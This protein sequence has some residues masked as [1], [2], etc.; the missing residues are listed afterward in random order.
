MTISVQITL[1]NENPAVVNSLQFLPALQVAF[2]NWS[3]ALAGDARIQVTL[4]IEPNSFFDG[5]GALASCVPVFVPIG[6]AVD[7][8][9]LFETDC[10]YQSI[11]GA[12]DPN[13]SATDMIININGDYTFWLDPASAP[14][15]GAYDLLTVLT[16]EIGH[17]IGFSGAFAQSSRFD[18]AT[19]KT[20]NPATDETPFDE[21]MVPDLKLFDGPNADKANGESPVLL[22]DQNNDSIYHI[23]SSD[24]IDLMN[25]ETPSG[26]RRTI[27]DLDIA[28]L[29]DLG[30]APK[31]EGPAAGAPGTLERTWDGD[32]QPMSVDGRFTAFTS[33]A[34]NLVPNDTN[35]VQD[36]FVYDRLTNTTERVSVSNDGTQ[37]DWHSF[38]PTITGDGRY[39]AFI[40]GASNLVPGSPPGWNNFVYD[41]STHQVELISSPTDGTATGQAL[42]ISPDGR[43]VAFETDAITNDGSNHG[44]E[45]FI[46]NR[47]AESLSLVAAD[48]AN[49]I[50][51]NNLQFSVDGRYL[52]F[53]SK[54]N[55]FVYDQINQSLQNVTSDGAGY[56]PSISADGRYIAF[57]HAT[58]DQ[59]TGEIT[60]GANIFV[61][62]QTTRT[63]ELISFADGGHADNHAF[64]P[65]I[66]GDGRYVVYSV[67]NELVPSIVPT[68]SDG[69]YVYDRLAHTTVQLGEGLFAQISADGKQVVV[70]H[71][72]GSISLT[73]VP[74]LGVSFDSVVLERDTGALNSDLA[75]QDGHVMLTGTMS[76][77]I[78]G[79]TV[80]VFDGNTLLDPVT[81]FEG[82][83]WLDVSL[84]DG[85]HNFS[86]TLTDINGD[87]VSTAG[88]DELV[89]DNTAAAVT[90]RLANDTG[91]S[92]TDRITKDAALIGSGDPNAVVHFII[93]GVQVA[94]TTNAD[95]SGA[96]SFAPAGL[97]DGQHTILAEETDLAG[98]V[99]AYP[100]IFTVD[101]RAPVDVLTNY[102]ANKNGTFTLSG[103]SEANMPITVIDGTTVLGATTSGSNG[104]W[105]FTTGVLSGA[106]V[107]SISTTATD[108]AGNV[109]TS[110]AVVYG[111]AA[112]NILTGTP[113]SDFFTGSAGADTFDFAGVHFGQDVVRDFTATGKS[114]DLLEFDHAAFASPKDA[115]NHAVQVGKDVIITYDVSDTVT[116]LGTHLNQL[117]TSDFH[118]V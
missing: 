5:T 33:D 80:Q 74:T 26:S 32:F 109:G 12:A 4:N 48:K 71:A 81:I 93:D 35:G 40:T 105:T 18:P 41:R 50:D 107:H 63:T 37:G 59:T 16:H 39:V 72:D 28:I 30:M 62:D 20:L 22:S 75:T 14:P 67:R 46:Y 91:I 64:Y 47:A 87:T 76:G 55:I 8:K 95:A 103:T 31:R 29:T 69:I 7:G 43:Y 36:I 51:G 89:I 104:Q 15:Q 98:N 96:W 110:G 1:N 38:D 19:G 13:G 114:H 106:V 116:L 65:S 17:G 112:N 82:S 73:A 101:T 94:D 111:T 78:D 117:T 49:G 97:A 42:T 108:A 58:V 21:H 90:I 11:A 102:V 44:V 113:F 53:Q 2:A 100:L 10:A 23:A 25:V 118:I 68:V 99:G 85:I 66:S 86:V 84:V 88:P 83:W 70:D 34:T 79:E 45:I 77:V 115:L 6:T 57:I 24:S 61:Y 9:T 3:N 60:D 92:S 27:S 54:N 52:V 56:I